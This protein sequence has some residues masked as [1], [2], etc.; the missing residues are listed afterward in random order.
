MS[1]SFL[2]VYCN[3]AHN[4]AHALR[5]AIYFFGRWGGGRNLERLNVERP[6]FRNLKIT[7][8]ETTK[9]KLLDIVVFKFYFLFF[10]NYFKTQNI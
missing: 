4:N 5:A 3:N 10:R 7:N 1:L 6:I 2:P 8:F 9:D